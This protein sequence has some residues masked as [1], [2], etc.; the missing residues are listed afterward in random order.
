MVHP[1]ER[2]VASLATVHPDVRQQ[3][4][5]LTAAVDDAVAA[6]RSREADAFA[7]ASTRLATFDPEQVR[8]VL[9]SVV[10]SLL[11]ERHPDGLDA[12]DVQAALERCLRSTLTWLPDVDVGA[13]VVVATGALGVHDPETTARV[14][15]PREIAVSAPLL[16]A[17]LLDG[18]PRPLDAHLLDAVAEIARAETVEMP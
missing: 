7:A 1:P 5:A 15:P 11:E 6:A 16:V 12:D 13:L 10:R 3:A 18:S 2:G 4:R 14:V 8:G 17:E 9:G